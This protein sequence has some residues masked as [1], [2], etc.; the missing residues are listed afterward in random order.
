MDVIVTE[1]PR[2]DR[3]NIPPKSEYDKIDGFHEI[4]RGADTILEQ[5][6]EEEKEFGVP[7]SQSKVQE[8]QAIEARKVEA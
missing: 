6:K 7:K 4:A 2:P 3:A 5:M 8:L 1:L